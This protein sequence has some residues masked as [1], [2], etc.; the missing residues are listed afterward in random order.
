M[1]IQ[2]VNRAHREHKENI[3]QENIEHVQ[4]NMSQKNI[5]HYRKNIIQA[6]G[7]GN[8]NKNNF[9]KNNKSWSQIGRISTIIIIFWLFAVHTGLQREDQSI[10]DAARYVYTNNM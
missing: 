8:N 6:H 3:S 5:E 4:R 2:N 7:R 10:C 9:K 1:T